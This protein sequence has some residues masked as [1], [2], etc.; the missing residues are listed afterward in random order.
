MKSQ[1]IYK[2]K[3][4]LINK[5]HRIDCVEGIKKIPDNSVHLLIT[6]PPYGIS[7]KL[8]CK[9]QQL[10][11]TAKLDF[12]FGKWDKMDVKWVPEA[13]NKT[14]GWAIIFCSQKDIGVYSTPTVEIDLKKCN[15]CGICEFICPDCALKVEK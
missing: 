15:A 9:G 3:S 4:D 8:N 14:S 10:G 7:R 13:L 2:I 1:T 11:S 12:E 6:D 5:I